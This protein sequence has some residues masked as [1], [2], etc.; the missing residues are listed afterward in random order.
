MQRLSGPSRRALA[1][2]VVVQTSQRVR[3]GV[4]LFALFACVADAAAQ[5]RSATI[6]GTVTDSTGAVLPGAAVVVTNQD[7]NATA[8]TITTD[9]GVFTVPYQ[10]AGTYMVSVSLAGF[11]PFKQT[12]IPVQT[13][14]TVRIAVELKISTLGETVEVG[15]STGLIQ[16]DS[17]SVE[18][19]VNAKMIEALP[20]I[21]QNPLQYAM[22]QAGAVG[23]PQ[24][25]ETNTTNSFGIGVGGRR[26]WSAVGVNGGRAFTN[27]IQLDGLPVMGGG[28]NEAAVVPNTEGL[29]E[30]RV[31]SNN[32][33]AE[34]GRGQAVIAMSTKSGTNKFTGQVS[35]LGRDER[36]DANTFSNNAQNIVK[37]PFRVH[38]F[39]GTYGGPIVRNKVFF[40]TSYHQ[41]RH[42][43]TTTNLMTVPTA[44]ERIG[45]FSQTMI[46]NENGQ[47]IPARIFD[48]FNVTQEGPDLYRRAEIPNARIPNP[49]AAALYMFSFYP[50]PNRAPDD[51]YNT[52]NF[53]AVVE[54]TIRRY[55]SNSRVD[56]R[57]G[58]HSI[59]GSG[60]ISY[61]EIVTPRPFGQSPFN[62]APGVNGDKNPFVQVG[63]AVVLGPSLLL[64][65]RYGVSRVNTKN[66]AGD[67][68][69][70]S[71]YD[72]FGV[73]ANLQAMMLFPGAAPIVNP[74][75]FGG[76]AGG[77]G[78]NWTAISGGTFS[79]KREYQTSHSVAASVTKT[80]GAWIH[81]AGFEYRNLLSNYADPEQASVVLPSPFHHVGGNFNFEYVTASGG[82]AS[83]TRTNAQRGI[84]AAGPLLGGGLWWI[85]PGANV[86]AAFSQKYIA[87]YSQNDWRA[88]QRLTINLGLRYEIQPGPTDRFNRMSAW[89]LDATSS[90]GTQ[91]AIA[92]AGVDGYSRNLWDTTY[93]NWGP[94]LGAAYQLSDR[95]VLRGGFGITYL[96]SNT[97]YFSGPTDYGS[98]NFS[99]GVSQIPYGLNPA[100]V[101][102]GTF[103][104]PVPLSPAIGGDESNPGVYGI[105]EARFD[106][107]Y[108][109][110]RMQ[111]WNVFLER[112]LG[113]AFMVSVGY[114][115]SRG[116]NLHNRSFPIQ[117][118]QNID[119]ATLDAWRA[120]YIASN[121]TLNPATQQ[122]P[123]PFQP[124]TGPRLAFA[125]PLAAA[126]ISRQNTLFPY[127]LLIGSVAAINRSD[128]ESR[129]HALTVRAARRL[130]AGLTFD[131][132]YTFSRERDNTD[133]VEDNQG[134][135]A[136][137]NARGGYDILDL[138]RNMHLGFSDLPHR[139][140]GTF[141]Y[142]LPFG[143]NRKFG[144]GNGVLRSIAR[145]WQVSG[146]LLWHSGFPVPI[147]GA[148]TG[149][150]V[151]R[152]DRVAGVDFELPTNLQGWYDGRTTI[153]L[154]SGRRI[155]P[156]ART[157]LRYNPDAFAGR[158]LTAPNG[159]II[160]D[161]FWYGNAELAYDG[162]RTDSRFNIDMSIRRTFRLSPTMAIDVGLD[163]MNVLNH[164]QF[165]GAYAGGL[166][167]T[168]L[169]N[170]PGNGQ[171]AGTAS[172][173]NFGTRGLGTYNPRQMQ[174]RI[175]LRF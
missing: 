108:E 45:D 36:L 135:N 141:F 29:Q 75:G 116:S 83:P 148:S 27:D 109:N 123:N 138:D 80:R 163:A 150:I 157:Y 165:N 40:F 6:T 66:L 59:Y 88:T 140:V 89:D 50:M 154:P 87:G 49:N 103:S 105:G 134:F 174:F 175:A 166:G 60:G 12:D 161:Q 106:R 42:N 114:S 73:P 43:N 136:G 112:R 37:R 16:T 118:L 54:Q 13:A 32:F 28:Y 58:R 158:V 117:S 128:A 79:T 102:V 64:D 38:D 62:G 67:K 101:P 70:F 74:N 160:A 100:G 119:Q 9:A 11:S 137:G 23:R 152:P 65:V 96:P 169:T 52:N 159:S 130:S 132:S 131:A 122:V 46:P 17:S 82:V 44:L 22:L 56:Y 34:Y 173:A 53:Q 99:A 164:T 72:R 14:Q 167:G 126:T 168:N 86:L 2:E 155:T 47:P 125:G 94:R 31:I 33:T 7:T 145:D 120:T 69:G 71:E 143:P 144:I 91:G 48:P 35:Y 146:S 8:D 24:S 156:P 10:Q 77:G 15:A 20:N 139:F 97:G 85:R 57:T 127:P 21:T 61:A 18:G 81:K 107:H 124:T 151:A 84:N 5:I 90:F 92:F 93:D 1:R 26:A 4:L 149:A 95:M 55:S 3:L 78:N 133:T 172:A 171:F 68:D 162:I 121:G 25:Q 41:L 142:E 110:G 129:Y 170:N 76:G 51:V 63:D 104:A 147:N 153:T 39:G 115:G 113:E 111:Q 30:V 98:A 19:A